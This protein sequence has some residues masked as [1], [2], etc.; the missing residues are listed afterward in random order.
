MLPVMRAMRGFSERLPFGLK[1]V[2]KRELK[3]YPPSHLLIPLHSKFIS[4][5]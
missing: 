1:G 5:K 4:T 2:Q 3:Q